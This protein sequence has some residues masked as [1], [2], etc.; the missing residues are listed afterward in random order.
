MAYGLMCWDANGIPT[1][2]ITDRLS[3][4]IHTFYI[5][6]NSDSGTET[7]PSNYSGTLFWSINNNELQASGAYAIIPISAVTMSISGN[8]ITWSRTRRNNATVSY[9]ILVIVG[10]Y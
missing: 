5:P 4:V 9:P 7:I 6:T 8:V 10:V 3:R 1:L 2:D